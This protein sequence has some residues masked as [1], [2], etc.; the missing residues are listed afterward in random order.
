[1]ANGFYDDKSKYQVKVGEEGVI[2]V[3]YPGTNTFGAYNSDGTTKTY[4]K[5]EE[6]QAFYDSQSGQ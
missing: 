4:F 3:Y 6:R 1:M 5:L 2:R